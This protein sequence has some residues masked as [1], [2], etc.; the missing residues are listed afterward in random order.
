MSDIT[1]SSV[2]KLLGGLGEQL[3]A[4]GERFELVVIG[5]S[6][7]LALRLIERTTR[8]VD[9]VAFHDSGELKG[10]EPLPAGLAAARDRV[11]KDFSLEENWL[12]AGPTKFLDFDLP[13]GFVDRMER[14]DYGPALVVY[15][16]SRRDQIH[17]K[18]YATV[19]EPGPGKHAADLRALDPTDEELIA[20]TQW[21]LAHNDPEG[22]VEPLRGVLEFFGV[23]NVDL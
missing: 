20:A 23:E 16:A 1:A 13:D 14:H 2:D 5:G 18:L 19:D 10:A 6:A 9:I 3:A 12:N 15:F 7:L 22:F 21:C 8:D 17:F 11:A 4:R